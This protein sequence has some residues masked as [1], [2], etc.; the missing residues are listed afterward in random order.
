MPGCGTRRDAL[1]ACGL[2]TP[3]SLLAQQRV[4]PP[5]HEPDP[6]VFLDYD[7]AELDAAY[8]QT[9]YAPNRQQ[10]QAR[11]AAALQAAGKKVDLVVGEGYNHFEFGETM[12]NP[13]GSLGRIALAQM[14][15]R[16][17]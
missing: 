11:F 7:Q 5:P 16:S 13:Y 4:G 2:L 1:R 15:L 8:D 6:K 12:A 9:A 17:A 3:I 10:M 14:N